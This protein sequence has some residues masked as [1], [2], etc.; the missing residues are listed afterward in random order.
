MTEIKTGYEILDGLPY[1]WDEPKDCSQFP[2]N[3][4]TALG[5]KPEQTT[6]QMMTY[7][8]EFTQ[9]LAEAFQTGVDY[10]TNGETIE[11]HYS[12]AWYQEIAG[13][14]DNSNL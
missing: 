8:K 3:L 11:N 14:D 1:K 6:F 5:I 4:K 12:V 13:E 10:A 2:P 9:A 7:T